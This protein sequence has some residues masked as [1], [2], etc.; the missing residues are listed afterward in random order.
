MYTAIAYLKSRAN[1]LNLDEKQLV[2][3]YDKYVDLVDR[4]NLDIYPVVIVKRYL[5]K[6]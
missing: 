5:E 2:E 1:R 3:I 4:E 6:I